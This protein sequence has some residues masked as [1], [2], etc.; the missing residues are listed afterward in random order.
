MTPEQISEANA[1]LRGKSPYAIARWAVE[2]GGGTTL[3]STN[4]RPY[5]AVILHICTQAQP[6]MKVLWMDSGWNRPATY[7]HAH[8]VIEKLKLN[9]VIYSPKTTVAH[10]H[11][12]NGEKIPTPDDGEL[13]KQFSYE[14]KIEPFQR[15]MKELAPKVWITG[16]RKVQNPNRANLDVVADDPNFNTLKVNPA[17]NMTDA[18][19]EAY[20]KDHNLPNEWDYFDPVKADEKRECGLHVVQSPREMGSGIQG[21][22]INE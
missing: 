16:L 20:L 9:V 3:V 21:M 14:T 13:F 11:A 5:E 7:R 4:F 19:M 8:E 1:A 10:W 2:Q 22:G 18:D 12:V 17:F 15:G 6:D